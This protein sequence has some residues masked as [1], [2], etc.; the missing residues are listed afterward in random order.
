MP[1]HFVNLDALIIREDFEVTA[2]TS[3]P[4]QMSGD[5]KLTELAAQ[6]IPYQMLRKPD[7]QRETSRW[8]PDK[9]V[10]LV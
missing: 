5:L 6:S 7:F 2:E 9:I 1:K 3:Q 10:D 4:R 8:T